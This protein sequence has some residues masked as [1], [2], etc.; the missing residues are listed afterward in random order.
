MKVVMIAAIPTM[1]VDGGGTFESGFEVEEISWVETLLLYKLPGFLLGTSE[2][3]RSRSVDFFVADQAN[4]GDIYALDREL[5][6]FVLNLGTSTGWQPITTSPAKK[7][8]C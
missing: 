1:M 4:P 7:F 3:D 8:V 5:N 2:G 6:A